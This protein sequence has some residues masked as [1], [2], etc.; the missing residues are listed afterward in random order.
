MNEGVVIVWKDEK[1]GGIVTACCFEDVSC[2][3]FVKKEA[4]RMVAQNQLKRDVVKNYSSDVIYDQISEYAV[5]SVF[6]CLKGTT[7][8]IY[9]GYDDCQ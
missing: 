3:G 5:D 9:V 4:Q 1:Y 8:I 6:E 2:G 7:E